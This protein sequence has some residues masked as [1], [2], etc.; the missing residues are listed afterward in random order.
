ME[1]L[2]LEFEFFVCYS[3]VIDKAL[4]RTGIGTTKK[5]NRQ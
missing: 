2:K 1:A 4:L 5:P 3:R